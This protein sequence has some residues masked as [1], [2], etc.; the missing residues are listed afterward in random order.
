MNASDPKIIER[1]KSWLSD[2]YDEDTKKEVR[3]MLENDPA[4]LQ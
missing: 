2:Q 3:N 4:E 1:A